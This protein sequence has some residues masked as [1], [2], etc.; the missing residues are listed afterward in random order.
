VRK[1]SNIKIIAQNKRARHDYFVEQ[2]IE[3]GIQLSG[4]EV[5]SIRQGGV[6]VKD[7][8]AAIKNQEVILHGMH[9]APYDKGNIN[10]L[11]PDRDRKL[12]LHKR[13]INKLIGLVRQKG[14]ALIPIKIYINTRYV[15]V[16][17]GV[18][19]GKKLYDKRQSMAERDDRREM[20]R[21]FKESYR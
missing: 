10:N 8:Y 11:E 12:L 2:I 21:K 9:I 16:E 1:G 6:N 5:K 13:E 14:M 7:S 17:L 15:K 19:R 18:C 4:T 20:E 3:A